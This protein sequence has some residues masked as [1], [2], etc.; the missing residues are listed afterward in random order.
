MNELSNFDYLTILV[1]SV[2]MFCGL[3][4]LL[5]WMMERDDDR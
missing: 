3:F 4:Y 5:R 2:S 1:A